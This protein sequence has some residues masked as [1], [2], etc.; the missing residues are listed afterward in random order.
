MP[1]F[2]RHIMHIGSVQLLT[3]HLSSQLLRFLVRSR[4][5]GIS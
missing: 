5:E 3:A 2:E 1:R 4:V